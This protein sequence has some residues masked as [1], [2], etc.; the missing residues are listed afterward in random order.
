M[1]ILYGTLELDKEGCSQLEMSCPQVEPLPQALPANG[2]AEGITIHASLWL[3]CSALG[4][5]LWYRELKGSVTCT[6]PLKSFLKWGRGWTNGTSIS[7][8]PTLGFTA[9]KDGW[10]QFPEVEC[11]GVRRGGHMYTRSKGQMGGY[12]WWPPLAFLPSVG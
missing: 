1:I 7:Q 8:S 5:K 4:G 9:A 2:T 11:Q 3:I 12:L 6:S 10:W